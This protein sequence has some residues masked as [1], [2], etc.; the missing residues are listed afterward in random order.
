MT[1]SGADPGGGGGG[2]GGGG[3]EPPPWPRLEI[4]FLSKFHYSV[5]ATGCNGLNHLNNIIGAGLSL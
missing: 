5:H 3:L 1:H 4:F 2:G